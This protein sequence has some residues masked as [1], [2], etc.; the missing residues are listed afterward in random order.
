MAL[1]F[2]Y[3]TLKRG[4]VNEYHM[5]GATYLGVV[6]TKEETYKMMAVID[7]DYPYPAVTHVVDNGCHIEGELYDISMPLMKFLDDFEGDEYTRG[8]VLLEDGRTAYLYFHKPK[9][10]AAPCVDN[11]PQIHYDPADNTVHWTKGDI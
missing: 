11:H 4:H 8:E 2:V 3:G 5:R 6:R 10:S 1:V 9:D 7:Y